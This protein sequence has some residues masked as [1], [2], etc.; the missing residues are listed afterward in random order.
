MHPADSLRLA[1]RNLINWI[2]YSG[3]GDW[4]FRRPV[5]FS[6]ISPDSKRELAE[7]IGYFWD[8][9]NQ[10]WKH[11]D[12]VFELPPRFG[13][14]WSSERSCSLFGDL[15]HIGCDLFEASADSKNNRQ[16]VA[17]SSDR[18]LL[19][20]IFGVNF[21]DFVIGYIKKN[22]RGSSLYSDSEIISEG[23]ISILSAMF[24]MDQPNNYSVQCELRDILSDFINKICYSNFAQQH[25]F[26][27]LQPLVALADLRIT[28]HGAARPF[29]M[30]DSD[31]L[32]HLIDTTSSFIA[33]CEKFGFD[34]CVGFGNALG[35]GREG[36]FL[37]HDC[38]LDIIL[39]GGSVS[40]E[41]HIALRSDLFEKL[42]A[43][44]WRCSIFD[45]A[46]PDAPNFYVERFDAIHNGRPGF[47]GLEPNLIYDTSDKENVDLSHLKSK[48][49]WSY[50][51]PANEIDLYGGK[52]KVPNSICDYLEAQYG[53]TWRISRPYAVTW[54]SD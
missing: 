29:S 28:T 24:R 31:S 3:F 30:Y 20:N 23:L 15:R 40:L 37:D 19:R 7:S 17:R 25:V 13:D 47:S 22:I 14:Y 45:E 21:D 6:F 50:L 36:M 11:F 33:D 5:P 16:G 46:Y 1:C 52:I 42:G 9:P 38:D 43:L 8:S 27:T 2:Q 26:D 41:N 35:V 48:L 49:K 53:P 54:N 4:V 39:G 12:E 10:I 34:A 18:W 51:F 44:G 32:T